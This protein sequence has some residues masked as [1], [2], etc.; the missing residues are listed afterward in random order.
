MS[1]TEKRRLTVLKRSATP[2]QK[3]QLANGKCRQGEKK[4]TCELLV[5]SIRYTVSS[6][7]G[8]CDAPT[9]TVQ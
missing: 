9:A 3:L 7:A 4:Q 1:L 6:F 5:W 8:D 2:Q